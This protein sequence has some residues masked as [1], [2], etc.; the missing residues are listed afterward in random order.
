MLVKHNV[1][2]VKELLS[3]Y[4]A[5]ISQLGLCDDMQNLIALRILIQKIV[6]NIPKP[7]RRDPNYFEFHRYLIVVHLL[8]MKNECIH[9]GIKSVINKINA[10]I[11]RYCKDIILAQSEKGLM[12]GW[13]LKL[14]NELQHGITFPT[15]A[16]GK[17]I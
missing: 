14:H 17:V 6:D 10:S 4:R 2:I 12:L 15:A 13:V 5:I 8:I 11:L 3:H 9:H 16:L 1:P 7:V